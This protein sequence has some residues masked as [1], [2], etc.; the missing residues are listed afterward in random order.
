MRLGSPSSVPVPSRCR[1]LLPP[2]YRER[3]GSA[4]VA[5]VT[6]HEV[7]PS[8][9]DE[10][11]PV[12]RRERLGK[13]RGPSLARPW[14]TRNVRDIEAV[15]VRGNGSGRVRMK[16]TPNASGETLSSFV[17]ETVSPGAIVHTD[18]WQGYAP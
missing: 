2:Q 12:P 4:K 9:P 15:E 6:A 11:R 7:S 18:G 3:C 17:A 1:A 16:V 14:R 13:P 8:A 5:P 10:V